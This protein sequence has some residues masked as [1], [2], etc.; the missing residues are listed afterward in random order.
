MHLPILILQIINKLINF[1]FLFCKKGGM[2]KEKIK[3][4][5]NF[6]KKLRKERLSWGMSRSKLSKRSHVDK[7]I[8]EEIEKGRLTHPN[9]YDVLNICD[10]LES[11]VYFYIE[12]DNNDG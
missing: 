5:K 8:I 7:F 2:M 9:F 11:S 12:K 3:W 6:G 10:V 4:K 1:S